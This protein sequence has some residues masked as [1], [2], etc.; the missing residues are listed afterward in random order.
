MADR[1]VGT[2]EFRENFMSFLRLNSG[3]PTGRRVNAKLEKLT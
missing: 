3:G 2:V 1:P